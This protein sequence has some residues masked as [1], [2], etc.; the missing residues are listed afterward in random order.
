MYSRRISIG[1]T[2]LNV[3]LAILPFSFFSAGM[4]AA[5]TAPVA[6]RESLTN[7]VFRVNDASAKDKSPS[8]PAATVAPVP[9]AADQPAATVASRSNPV[10]TTSVPATKPTVAQTAPAAVPATPTVVIPPAP[11]EPLASELLGN[12]VVD[13]RRVLAYLRANVSDYTCDFI[14]QERVDGKLL[15]KEFMKLKVRN[16]VV[17]EGQ[18]VQPF[19]VY[20]K[21][22]TPSNY[23]NREVLFVEGHNNEKLLIKEGGA[24]GRFLPS[25]WLKKTNMMITSVNRYNI[26]DAG[27]N[28][29]IERLIEAATE[30]V[31]CDQE[32]KIRYFQQGAKVGGHN[33]SYLEVIRPNRNPGPLGPNNVYLAQVYIDNSLN[34]PI[35]YAAYDWPTK[36]GGRP[37]LVEEYIY[38]NVVMNPGLTDN[39]FNPKNKDY[40]F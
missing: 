7:P 20:M 30:N 9:A 29:M 39:D 31:N 11:V 34:I 28:K 15:P 24:R 33:C 1:A 32:C 14:K 8:Q 16:K 13:A 37:Q 12:A 3:A 27:M 40:R 18:I 26:T 6:E 19:S 25:V 5:Q 21:F 36:V 2:T 22:K 4:V 38:Q 23:K 35:H 17:R 10:A